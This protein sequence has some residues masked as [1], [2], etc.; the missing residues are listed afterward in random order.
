MG[1]ELKVQL[2]IEEG[3]CRASRRC[4]APVCFVCT[5]ASTLSPS[6]S[7]LSAP[8]DLPSAA[9]VD[10][11]QGI[12]GSWTNPPSPP[13]SLARGSGI[14]GM[15]VCS[16]VA[17]TTLHGVHGQIIFERRDER[18]H[19]RFPI[20]QSPFKKGTDARL[21]SRRV[22]GEELEHEHAS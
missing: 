12:S 20:Q 10:Q 1:V 8:S 19:F 4:A 3:N 14:F 15:R 16:S 7:R 13:P 18:D 22:A 2:Q 9:I 5:Q 21:A 11:V 17:L 6:S